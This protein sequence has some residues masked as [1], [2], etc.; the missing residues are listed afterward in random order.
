MSRLARRKFSTETGM[1]DFKVMGTIT[2]KCARNLTSMVTTKDTSLGK[3]I[4]DEVSNILKT[5]ITNVK[6]DLYTDPIDGRFQISTNY[7]TENV[8][9]I[10]YMISS[11]SMTIE[12]GKTKVEM[13]PKKIYFV[14][15]R[16]TYRITK[17]NSTN[18]ALMSGIFRWDKEVHGS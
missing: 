5:P 18:T 12:Y 3:D 11:G 4:I 10:F 16:T 7:D 15:D 14:N 1:P 6:A 13:Q 2:D 17:N 8:A 9:A